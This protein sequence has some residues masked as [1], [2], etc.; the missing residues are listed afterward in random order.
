MSWERTI[1]EADKF[2]KI[3]YP[4]YIELYDRLQALPPGQ[5][6]VEDTKKLFEM[7]ER[8]SAMKREIRLASQER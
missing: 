8:L 6:K 5:I 2:Q 1:E 3:F 4:A 7:H